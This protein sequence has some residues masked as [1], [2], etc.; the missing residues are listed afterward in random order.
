MRTFWAGMIEFWD[1]HCCPW[2]CASVL[3]WVVSLGHSGLGSCSKECEL[4]GFAGAQ[5]P[6]LWGTGD[7]GC[8]AP[9]KPQEMSTVSHSGGSILQSHFFPLLLISFV[10]VLGFFCSFFP[11]SLYSVVFLHEWQMKAVLVLTQMIHTH[12]RTLC[13][14]FLLIKC[15]GIGV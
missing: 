4:H 12:S 13:P 11:P 15:L 6:Q 14:A 2:G 9:R 7:R 8:L 1:D 3:C 10:C 5:L